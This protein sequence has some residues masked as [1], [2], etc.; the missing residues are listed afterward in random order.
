MRRSCAVAI[1][2][3]CLSS[4][5]PAL[6]QSTSAVPSPDIDADERSVEY[7][8]AY[9][10][11]DDGGA[12]GFAHRIHY[13]QS[14]GEDWRVR[15]ILQQGKRGGAPLKT[16]AVGV[17]FFTQFVESETTGGWGS[18]FRFDGFIPVEDGRPGRARVLWLNSF[19]IGRELQLRSN[20]VL[21]REFGDNAQ[22]GVSLEFREEATWRLS[23]DLRLGALAFHN[24]NTTTRFGSFDEQRHQIGPALRWKATKA[25]R[26]DASV[27][28][29]VSG[30]ATDAD[31]RLFASYGF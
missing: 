2:L 12:D 20:V 9:G 10:H 25:L 13:Q 14:L 28:F 26:I 7:R 8:A 23:D 18:G 19:D 5:L 15:V 29:G 3:A 24:L 11:F 21:G 27:L 30:A 16:Q 22:E 4:A 1:A 31:F 6:A 17:Q